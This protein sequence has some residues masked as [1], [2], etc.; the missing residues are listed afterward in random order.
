MVRLCVLI[1]I[2]LAAGPAS[3]A[4]RPV[5]F[6]TDVIAAL[7]RVGC[8]QGACHGSPQ[9]KNGFRLSLRGADPDFDFVTL[10]KDQGGRRV[11]RQTPD[12][13]LILQKGSGRVAHQGGS[14]FGRDHAAYRVLARW[15]ADGCRMDQS[16]ALARLEVLPGDARLPAHAPRLALQVRAH[17]ADGSTR[18][19]TDLADWSSFSE[20]AK[21]RSSSAISPR[22][23]ACG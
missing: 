22:S 21:P 19:V 12:D 17:F 8:N 6:R 16:P 1:I 3:A 20:R 15:I 18:D 4:E 2:A 9:G 13:S 11:N 14:L 5:D 10:V 7:S 23:R